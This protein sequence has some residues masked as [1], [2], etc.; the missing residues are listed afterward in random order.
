MLKAPALDRVII[1]R[2][3][4]F[5]LKLHYPVHVFLDGRGFVGRLL[6]IPEV[7][8]ISDTIADLYRQIEAMR[9]IWISTAILSYLDVPLPNSHHYAPLPLPNEITDT[10]ERRV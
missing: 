6:D 9:R 5:F 8:C 2:K 3:L 1:E 7:E 4:R 10:S